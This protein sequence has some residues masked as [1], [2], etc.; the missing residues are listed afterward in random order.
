MKN[1]IILGDAIEEMKKLEDCSVDCVVTSPPYF[2]LL[3]YE[4]NFNSYLQFIDWSDKWIKEVQRVLKDGGYFFLNF[5]NDKTNPIKSYEM[6]QIGTKYF[7]LHD[8]IIWYR[9]NSQPCNTDRQLTPQYEFVFMFC[10][11]PKNYH[12]NKEELYKK[13]PNLFDTKNVGNVWK[14]AFNKG[15]EGYSMKKQD[16][17]ASNGLWGH[18]G[19]PLDLPMACI[20]LSTKEKDLVLDPFSGFA[21]T[22]LACKQ[23]NR[24]YLGF[25]I[26]KEYRDLGN[27]RLEQCVLPQQKE[28][29]ELNNNKNLKGGIENGKM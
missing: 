17:D 24:N 19:F 12:L 2:K 21:T 28:T 14:L 7:T 8:T 22:A 3:S 10:K 13:L 16:E 9:Y 20:I 27:K 6:L 18:S 11:N 4:S 25:E 23:L 1:K 29:K 26:V 5:A 15:K